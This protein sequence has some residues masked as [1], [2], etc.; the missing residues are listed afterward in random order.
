MPSIGD[1]IQVTSYK[2]VFDQDVVNIYHYLIS[3]WSGAVSLPALLESWNVSEY[4]ALATMQQNTLCYTKQEWLNLTTG[5]ETAENIVVG[6]R[7]G[8]LSTGE[9]MPT[10]DAIGFRLNRASNLT[11]HGYKRIGGIGEGMSLNGVANLTGAGL[12]DALAF[13]GDEKTF[14]TNDMIWSPVI[15]GRTLAGLPDLTRVNPVASVSMQSRIT[16]QLTRK[17]GRGS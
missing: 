8:L 12:T 16:T 2:R 4:G 5:V 14:G 17:H 13:L 1:V 15:V 10:H 9:T 7:C 11:R 3:A 6:T